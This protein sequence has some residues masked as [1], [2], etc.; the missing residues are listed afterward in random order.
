MHRII[1]AALVMLLAVPFIARGETVTVG[2]V[3]SLSPLIRQLA[4]DYQARTPGIDVIVVDPPLGTSGGMRALAAGK[5]DLVLSG[6]MPKADEPAQGK[7]WLRTPLVLASNGGKRAGLTRADIAEIYAGSKLTWDDQQ[8]IRL[9]LRGE[10][11]TETRDLRSVSPAIDAA[12][13]Q[14]LKRTGLPVAENDLDALDTL[15]RIKGS[16]G[17]TTLG[18]L[19]AHGSPLTAFPID[20]VAP[21]AKNLEAGRYTL[22]RNYFLVTGT[23]ASPATL[24]FVKW[25]NAPAALAKARGLEYLPLP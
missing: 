1:G 19:K 10:T 22:Q 5:V 7:P 21:S 13:A 8:T 17:T 16:L 18:L 24:A 6:R 9:I 25:L 4:A 15:Q 14:A 2:G 11:E 3:G 20:G 23:R 12:Y